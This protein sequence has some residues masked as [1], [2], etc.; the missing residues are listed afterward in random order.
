MPE[1]QPPQSSDPIEIPARLASRPL[2]AYT[3]A[4]FGVHEADFR[5]GL[6]SIGE[7]QRRGH[8]VAF[9]HAGRT[10]RRFNITA[11]AAQAGVD[12]GSACSLGDLDPARLHALLRRADVLI[13]PGHPTEFNR[14]RLPSKL[15][16]Y[17]ASGSPTVTFA[18]G[19]GELLVD[20]EEVLKTFDGDPSEL[21]DRISEA[22]FDEPLRRRLSAGGPRAAERLFNTRRNTDQLIAHYRAA[23]PQ[24]GSASSV[25]ALDGAYSGT[26]NGGHVP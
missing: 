11:M 21:A 18:I 14:L 7:L 8:H 1:A 9:I 3:G 16:V 2:V 5:L 15:Q 4:V 12:P 24:G 23:L 26:G 22:L 10:A 13:Q 19:A 25:R 6:A 17:L 20:R